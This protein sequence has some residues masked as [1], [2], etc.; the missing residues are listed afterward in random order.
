MIQQRSAELQCHGSKSE[1]MARPMLWQ[2]WRR[3]IAQFAVPVSQ[4]AH[5]AGAGRTKAT[6][7]AN[8]NAQRVENEG[9]RATPSI[10]KLSHSEP[11]RQARILLMLSWRSL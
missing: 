2:W 1:R 4:L 9:R 8:E 11:W 3:R 7:T 6:A 10:P 5:R